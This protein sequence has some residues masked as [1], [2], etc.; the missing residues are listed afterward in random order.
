MG[1]KNTHTHRRIP[2]IN[3]QMTDK[4]YAQNKTKQ[5]KAK[6]KAKKWLSTIHCLPIYSTAIIEHN[7]R[8]ATSLHYQSLYLWEY[9][10][11]ECRE[12]RSAN[13]I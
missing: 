4:E 11:V 2:S 8:V 6:A 7:K 5:S 12:Y 1:K 13:H 3:Y 9:A 10:L